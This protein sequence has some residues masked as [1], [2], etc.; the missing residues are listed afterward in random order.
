[1]ATPKVETSE[2]TN[3]KL[4]YGARSVLLH[5][6]VG[7]F[8]LDDLIYIGPL[9]HKSED[10]EPAYYITEFRTHNPFQIPKSHF[11]QIL[12]E[13]REFDIVLKEGKI[14]KNNK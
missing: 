8:N 9:Y 1:M 6:S 10:E 14:S 13:F 3:A 11:E 5:T 4:V 12:K 2:K 7:I